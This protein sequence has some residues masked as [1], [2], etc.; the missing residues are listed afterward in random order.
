MVSVGAMALTPVQ[1]LSTT[2]APVPQKTISALAVGLAAAVTPISPIQNRIDVI[3]DTAARVLI[4]PAG[5]R[6][7]GQLFGQL[8]NASRNCRAEASSTASR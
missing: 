5:G 8:P 2:L 7:G 1:P 3:T 4:S 6:S